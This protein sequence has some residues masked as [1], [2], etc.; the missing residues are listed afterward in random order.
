MVLRK[1]RQESEIALRHLKVLEFVKKNQP[2][3]IFKLAELMN[4]PKHKIRYSLRILEHSGIIEP[5]QYGAVLRE[6]SEKILENMKREIKE[7]GKCINRLDQVI[8]KL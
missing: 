7:L 4:V 3:G 1:L 5:T 8:Q 2:I 6:D